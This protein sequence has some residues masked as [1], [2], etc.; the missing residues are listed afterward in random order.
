[1]SN[2]VTDDILALWYSKLVKRFS[3]HCR[4][5]REYTYIKKDLPFRALHMGKKH[6]EY[7]LD[8]QY[9][10]IPTKDLLNDLNRLIIKDFRTNDDLSFENKQAKTA[11]SIADLY[12]EHETVQIVIELEI[13]KDKPFSNLI[14]IPEVCKSGRK[15]PFCFIHCFAPERQDKEAELTR[16]I[17]LWLL[18]QPAIEKFEYV[19]FIMPPLPDSIKY[20]LLKK[21]AVKPKLYQRPE[22]RIVFQEYILNFYEQKIIPKVNGCLVCLI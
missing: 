5:E 22:D 21:S 3:H 15:I 14:Y 8:E 20:L 16:Q 2:F 7:F 11:R 19:S 4:V 10:K 12:I 6:D 1:M 9:K 17:G 18:K 13:F